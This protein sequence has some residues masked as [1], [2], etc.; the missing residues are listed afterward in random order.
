[1]GIAAE[2]VADFRNNADRRLRPG[3]DC[4]AVANLGGYVGNFVVYKQHLSL[5]AQLPIFQA[6]QIAAL[7]WQRQDA[8]ETG[9]STP[10]RLVSR[11]S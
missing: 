5:I 4:T 11:L 7:A 2:G 6:K 1:M 3:H 8:Q 9:H 10:T